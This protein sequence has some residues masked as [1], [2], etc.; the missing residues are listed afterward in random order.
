MCFT[1]KINDF[2]R[3]SVYQQNLRY[4]CPYIGLHGLFISNLSYHDQPQWFCLVR[5][6]NLDRFGE[7]VYTKGNF[8]GDSYTKTK[9]CSEELSKHFVL[10]MHLCPKKSSFFSKKFRTS[11]WCE[12]TPACLNIKVSKKMQA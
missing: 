3:K 6:A 2:I 9:T 4:Y 8:F 11:L 5:L 12:F 10:S 1:T 7:K